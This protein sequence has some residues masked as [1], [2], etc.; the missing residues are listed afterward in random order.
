MIHVSTAIS[1]MK[2][3][4]P[5]LARLVSWMIASLSASARKRGLT[6]KEVAADL[7]LSEKTVKN[8]LSRL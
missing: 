7:G 2:P 5:P 4:V 6:N 8:Y 3:P 1:S